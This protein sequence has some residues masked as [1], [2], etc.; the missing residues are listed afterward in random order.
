MTD[1]C[2]FVFWGRNETCLEKKD[3][4]YKENKHVKNYQNLAQQNM[5]QE[6]FCREHFKYITRLL[7]F[8]YLVCMMQYSEYTRCSLLRLF[9][10]LTRS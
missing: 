4:S 7:D 2:S 3:V 6:M 8:F 10:L 1:S 9:F 5:S